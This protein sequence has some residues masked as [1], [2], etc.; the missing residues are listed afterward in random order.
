MFCCFILNGKIAHVE[1][2]VRRLQ[3]QDH[4][5]IFDDDVQKILSVEVDR[6]IQKVSLI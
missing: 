4:D 3:S 6:L 2:E 5:R 1:G